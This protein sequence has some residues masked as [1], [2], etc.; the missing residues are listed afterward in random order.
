M[1]VGVK[2][3]I[4]EKCSHGMYPHSHSVSY[5]RLHINTTWKYKIRCLIGYSLSKFKKK[6]K[7]QILMG[8]YP[9][10]YRLIASYRQGWTQHFQAFSNQSSNFSIIRMG[11]WY[12]I[13]RTEIAEVLIHH[14]VEVWHIRRPDGGIFDF[15]YPSRTG[16]G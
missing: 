6:I 14:L 2:K 10:I 9:L 1:R 5:Y 16:I 3:V 8:I 4:L 7:S 11:T 12:L 15:H 13:R